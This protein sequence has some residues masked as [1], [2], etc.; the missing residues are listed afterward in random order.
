MKKKHGNLV[1][2]LVLRDGPQGL[3][4]EPLF[5]M[6]G[7]DME[8]FNAHFSFQYVK[9]PGTCHPVEGMLV[10]PYDECLVFGSL[11]REDML[12]LG[13][14][15]SIVLGEEREKYIINE[16]SVVCIPKG[17][18]HGPIKYER[19]DRPFVHY[20]IGLDPEYKASPLAT[21]EPVSGGSKY[22]HLI[23]RLVTTLHPGADP[24]DI[25]V[26]KG[27]G[28][29]YEHVG[30]ERGILHPRE[31]GIGP[32][33]GDSVVWLYGSDLEGFELNFTWGHYSACGKWHRAGEMHQHPE[34][35]ILVFVGGDPDRPDYLGA[36]V[37]HGMGYECERHI[38][39]TPG[40]YIC[41]KGFPHLP[42]I[43]R[44]CD[45][46]FCFF[47]ICLSGH[48]ASPWVEVEVPEE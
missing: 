39:N 10:H 40:L 42:M 5:W 26:G 34:E 7:K 2:K 16:P 23:K 22:R 6:E 47:V 35:E 32:G 12:D 41:P 20:A 36:E 13:G 46:P 28:M 11:N 30:D 31:R 14:E 37:E 8:G 3:Y 17:L 48:H 4:P 44:W 29:G 1:K 45:Q 21:G 27:S 33:N 24:N 18:P 19:V 38:L 43:T 25:D 15:I 9:G